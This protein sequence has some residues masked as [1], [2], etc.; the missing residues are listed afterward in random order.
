M[1]YS[2][3]QGLQPMS[4]CF[5]GLDIQSLQKMLIKVGQT[6]PAITTE[7]KDMS[8]L[9]NERPGKG[10]MYWE[11][12]ADRKSPQA[13]DFKGFVVLECDYKAGEKLKLAAWMKDTSRGVK[14][15]SLS[16]DNWSKKQREAHHEVE[17]SYQRVNTHPG[18]VRKFERKID[19]NEIPF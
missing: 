8:N 9:H 2:M 13:P 19:D 3:T 12:E 15:L 6:L 10:V 1:R 17:P 16:E 7:R 5:A 4:K 11:N 14:L 18:S